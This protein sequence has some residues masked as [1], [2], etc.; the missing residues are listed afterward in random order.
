MTQSSKL[1][2]LDYKLVKNV[3]SVNECN[4]L[5][6]LFDNLESDKKRR[7]FEK[8]LGLKNGRYRMSVRNFTSSI[9][10][11]DDQHTDDCHHIVQKCFDETL[12]ANNMCWK[13]DTLED[14]YYAIN[15]Y[16]RSQQYTV[17]NDVQGLSSNDDNRY[18]ITQPNNILSFSMLLSD[19]D[20]T[21]GGDLS[22]FSHDLK[23]RVDFNNIN[24]GDLVVYPS[25]TAHS[26]SR[27][28][29]GRRYSL[30]G[31][32]KGASIHD[33]EYAKRWLLNNQI[34]IVGL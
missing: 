5:I 28:K 1:K 27:V 6:Q 9:R 10:F 7:F 25:Y 18:V 21:G 19:P 20:S 12:K 31:I 13:F 30:M 4:H 11:V 17:H 3:L 26:V 2:K 8:L 29:S 34:E 22:L 32:V 24:R 23:H 14:M 15:S 16:Q 33:Q